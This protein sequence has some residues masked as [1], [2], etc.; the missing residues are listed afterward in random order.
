MLHAQWVLNPSIRIQTNQSTRWSINTMVFHTAII[1]ELLHN[2]W[3][4]R[5]QSKYSA[6][7]IIFIIINFYDRCNITGKNNCSRCFQRIITMVQYNFCA[8]NVNVYAF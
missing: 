4:E 5:K 2:K 7:C 8:I 6:E 3:N 1:T